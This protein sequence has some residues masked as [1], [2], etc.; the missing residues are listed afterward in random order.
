MDLPAEGL[1]MPGYFARKRAA[2][3]ARGYSVDYK[4]LGIAFFIEIAV[5]YTSLQGAWLFADTYARDSRAFTMMML[6]PIAYA[7]VELSRVPL[8]FALRTQTSLAWK[9]VF[10][11]LV[12]CAA[13]V[14]VKSLSQLGEIMF[15]PRLMDVTESATHL[16]DMRAQAASVALSVKSADAVVEQRREELRA[17]QDRLKTASGAVTGLPAEKC[18]TETRRT[19]AGVT[20]AR[21]CRADGRQSPLIGE[22]KDAQTAR[23]TASTQFDAASAERAKLS[24]AAADSR[25]SDADTAYRKAVM[26]SQLHSFTAM[27]FG[28]EPTQVTDGEIHFFLRWFVFFPAIFASLAA[29]GLAL[30]SVTYPRREEK[31]EAVEIDEAALR[32]YVLEPLVAEV[33]NRVLHAAEVDR[34]RVAAAAQGGTNTSGEVVTPP[35]SVNDN[36]LLKKV[37]GEAK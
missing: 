16:A 36:P 31:V 26:N 33:Q 11:V 18:W 29:T 10:A 22:L 5:I 13:A 8:A 12:L 34:A 21:R 3:A 14:T 35:P 30:A 1:P 9:V 7:G 25:V 32:A 2:N 24:T 27:F 19:A 23:D 20:R 37:A 15:R 17:T 4:Y 28:K 6:A